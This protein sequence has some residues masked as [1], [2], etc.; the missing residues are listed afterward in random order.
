[1]AIVQAHLSL[2]ITP[3]EGVKR[4]K[5]VKDIPLFVPCR[6]SRIEE[7]A[8][9]II[10]LIPSTNTTLSPLDLS[11]IKGCLMNSTNNGLL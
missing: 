2:S 6:L 11:R 8:V 4:E 9:I 5:D 10:S 7:E 1:M 3:L